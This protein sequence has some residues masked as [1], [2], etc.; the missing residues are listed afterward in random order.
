MCL[1]S[2]RSRVSMI[3]S[4]QKDRVIILGGEERDGRES[5]VVEEIDFIKRNSVVSLREMKV[6]RIQP[7][8]FMV[9]ESIYVFGG[10]K[11]SQGLMG[12]KYVLSGDKWKEVKPKNLQELQS[13]YGVE[14]TFG[15]A[16]LLYE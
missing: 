7:Q 9:N 16:S 4:H 8:V 13:G 3:S 5:T 2:P 1:S 15:P 12:E 10:T 11:L 14:E 6:G